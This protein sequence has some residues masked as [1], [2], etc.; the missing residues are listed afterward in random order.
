MRTVNNMVP[1]KKTYSEETLKEALRAIKHGM[2]FK[3]AAIRFGVPRATLQFRLS[4][5]FMKISRGPAPVLN[6]EE[7]STLVR[8]IFECAR[9]GFP[10]HKEN[11]QTNVKKFLQE[12]D[13]PN[14]FKDNTPGDKWYNSFLKRHPEVSIR[15]PEDITA[16]SVCVSQEYIRGWFTAVEDVLKEQNVYYILSYPD[17]IFNGDE[18]NFMLCPKNNIILAPSGSKNVYE[19]E[20]G[21]TKAT[22]TVMY[23]FSAAGK[24]IHNL[25]ENE[26]HVEEF[27]V[28]YR[29]WEHYKMNN[30][31]QDMNTTCT[32]ISRPTVNSPEGD[33][34]DN[35]P[36]TVNSP[37]DQAYNRTPTLVNDEMNHDQQFVNENVPQLNSTP[38]IEEEQI[39]IINE[40][41]NKRTHTKENM[42]DILLW[43][44]TP[45]RKGKRKIERVSHILTSGKWRELHDQKE[46]QKGDALKQKENRKLEREKEKLEK[47]SAETRRKISK[48]NKKLEKDTTILKS[49]HT[50]ISQPSTS[51]QEEGNIEI[52][53]KCTR[54]VS[55]TKKG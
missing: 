9:K 50:V 17:R 7:E 37:E 11:L 40:S 30:N 5:K 18:T 42:C 44:E 39:E 14:P 51:R 2:S 10:R 26:D 45:K 33:I 55:T 53:F 36:L 34:C 27:F 1:H 52:C 12:N 43:S 28:L 15:T 4:K 22:L 38:N 8:W 19:V 41:V 49:I 13:C 25:V 29:L 32:E 16:A 47:I 31:A 48:V 20:R 23:S 24:N 6:S 3:A 54:T 21:H 35:R 46:K